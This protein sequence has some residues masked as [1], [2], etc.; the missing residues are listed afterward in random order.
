MAPDEVFSPGLP[1]TASSPRRRARHTLA[2]RSRRLLLSL[3]E[4]G[5][6]KVPA[7]S[8]GYNPQASR[9]SWEGTRWSGRS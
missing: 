2:V 3:N 1:A 6:A 7:D 5:P 8:D 9:R 4:S